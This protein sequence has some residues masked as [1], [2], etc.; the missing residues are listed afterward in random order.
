MTDS[1]TRLR[2]LPSPTAPRPASATLWVDDI[3]IDPQQVV[4]RQRTADMIKAEIDGAIARIKTEHGRWG[5][6]GEVE[7]P[8]SGLCHGPIVEEFDGIRL[9]YFCTQPTGH[10]EPCGP[11]GHGDEPAPTE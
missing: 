9:E 1:T 2:A 10:A 5:W 8:D 7:L 6:E 4:N 3:T 11:T